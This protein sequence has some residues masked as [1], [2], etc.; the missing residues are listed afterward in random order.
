MNPITFEIGNRYENM[1]GSYEVLA[2]DDNVMRIKWEDGEEIT[3]SIIMQRRIL[4]RLERERE[5]ANKTASPE[6]EK[7]NAGTTHEKAGEW[8]S[9]SRKNQPVQ[10]TTGMRKKYLKTRGVCKVTF[11]S[12]TGITRPIP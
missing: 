2:V 8:E 12:M 1:K 5:V 10:K 3:T 11:I 6:T 7:A 4:E 9:T